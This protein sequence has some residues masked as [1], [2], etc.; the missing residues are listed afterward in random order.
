MYWSL[1]PRFDSRFVV[2]ETGCWEWTGSK[3]LYG[4]G[5]ILL[6][7]GHLVSA[8][9]ASWILYKG[10][11]PDKLCVLHKCDNPP[12]V[13]PEH[14]FLGT[15]AENNRDKAEKMRS[16]LGERSPLAKLTNAQAVEIFALRDTSLSQQEVGDRFGVSKTAIRHIWSGHRWGRI[17][18]FV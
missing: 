11:I 12:C 17:T 9:R 15:R 2:M 13:N 1:K 5:A 18:G 6:A 10:P 7:R 14:L 4:Y 8:H 16:N 3:S